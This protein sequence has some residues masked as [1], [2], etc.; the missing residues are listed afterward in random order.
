M[1]DPKKIV[2]KNESELSSGPEEK[3]IK[4]P[5]EKIY[6]SRKKS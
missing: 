5:R 6:A 4:N 1:R 2:G 3:S